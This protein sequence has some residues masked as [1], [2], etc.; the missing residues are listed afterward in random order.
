MAQSMKRG[1]CTEHSPSTEFLCVSGMDSETPELCW[2]HQESE[3]THTHIG[4]LDG[5][6]LRAPAGAD[7]TS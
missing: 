7:T 4:F 2:Y 5:E 1:H 6:K 3:H